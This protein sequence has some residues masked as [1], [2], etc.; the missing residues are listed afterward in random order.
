MLW[1]YHLTVPGRSVCVRMCPECHTARQVL[2]CMSAPRMAAASKVTSLKSAQ[3]LLIYPVL[4]CLCCCCQRR[5]GGGRG[6]KQLAVHLCDRLSDCTSNLSSLFTE[7]CFPVPVNILP[8]EPTS[9]E[10]RMNEQSG[11]SDSLGLTQS[12]CGI[13]LSRHL[14]FLTALCTWP[15]PQE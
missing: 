4:R 9:L 12:F 7:A 5:R 13:L 8:P 15:G 6:E 11:Y 14:V 10:E 1:R 3:V 2:I